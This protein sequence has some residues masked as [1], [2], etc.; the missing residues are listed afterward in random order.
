LKNKLN[1]ETDFSNTRVFL[2][3]SLLNSLIKSAK[4]YF[5]EEHLNELQMPMLL[6]VN[7]PTLTDQWIN[8]QTIIRENKNRNELSLQNLMKDLR[9]EQFGE[10]GMNYKTNDVSGFSYEK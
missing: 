3:L 6:Q 9:I 7:C 8:D 5:F 4:Q 10:I 2:E 1:T